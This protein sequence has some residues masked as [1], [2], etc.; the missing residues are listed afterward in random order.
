MAS[1][2]QSPNTHAQTL[3][4]ISLCELLAFCVH[5]TASKANQSGSPV[6][7]EAS[8]GG[9][10]ATHTV[11]NRVDVALPLTRANPLAMLSLFHL[12][13]DIA[14]RQKPQVA[15]LVLHLTLL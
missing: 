10:R 6:G 12:E 3:D 1:M 5:V 9:V 14:R 7:Y 8:L 13:P 15:L 2:S 11:A 4:K